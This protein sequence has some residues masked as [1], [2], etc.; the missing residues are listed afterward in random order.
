MPLERQVLGRITKVDEK[1]GTKRFDFS[2]RKSLVVFGSNALDRSEIQEQGIVDVIILQIV[3][4]KAF[5][6]IKGTYN[7]LKIKHFNKN[8]FEIGDI[9][10][11]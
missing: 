11:V 4:D 6:S 3:N 2:L 9:V 8:A 10:K 7:K 5:G 1:T